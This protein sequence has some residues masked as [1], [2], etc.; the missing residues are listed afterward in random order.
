MMFCRRAKPRTW[1]A[2]S[3]SPIMAA[4]IATIKD[5]RAITNQKGRYPNHSGREISDDVENQIGRIA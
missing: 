5:F 4:S 3:I 2:T 1:R